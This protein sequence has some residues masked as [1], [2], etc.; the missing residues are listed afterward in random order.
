MRCWNTNCRSIKILSISPTNFSLAQDQFIGIFWENVYLRSHAVHCRSNWSP[1]LTHE[2]C[3]HPMLIVSPSDI[4]L[5]LYSQPAWE[6]SRWLIAD[7]FFIFNLS[8][9]NAQIFTIIAQASSKL[10]NKISCPMIRCRSSIRYPNSIF[11]G[12][13]FRSLAARI[14]LARGLPSGTGTLDTSS[15]WHHVT[16]AHLHPILLTACESSRHQLMFLCYQDV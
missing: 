13:Y 8:F 9:H 14:L 16:L 4:N 2:Q 7:V 12:Q 5:S 6:T 15:Y 11:T 1:C 10:K 3:W